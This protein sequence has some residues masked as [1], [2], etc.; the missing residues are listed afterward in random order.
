[1]DI[2]RKRMINQP[3]QTLVRPRRCYALPQPPDPRR[4][5]GGPYKYPDQKYAY[6]PERIHP[7]TSLQR[8]TRLDPARRFRRLHCA[9]KQPVARRSD[10]RDS[11]S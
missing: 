11:G 6:R 7:T 1:M 2:A 4:H 8:T 5:E 10:H 3:V 9:S